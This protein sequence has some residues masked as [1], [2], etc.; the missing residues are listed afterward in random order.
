M[1]STEL[2]D[3]ALVAFLQAEDKSP[4]CQEPELSALLDYVEGGKPF[5]TQISARQRVLFDYLFTLGAYPEGERFQRIYLLLLRTLIRT[6]A[7]G[8][9]HLWLSLKWIFMAKSYA[10]SFMNILKT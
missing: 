9:L 7:G 3:Q 4:W 5:A 8:P 2:I 6:K 10:S 1:K